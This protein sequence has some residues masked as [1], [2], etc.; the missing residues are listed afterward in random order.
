M[1]FATG[2]P[3]PTGEGETSH[4]SNQTRRARSPGITPSLLAL[5]AFLAALAPATTSQALSSKS[6]QLQ[7]P[8]AGVTARQPIHLAPKIATVTPQTCVR[9]GDAVTLGGSNFGFPKPAASTLAVQPAGG[10]TLITVTERSWSS[11]GITFDV[12]AGLAPESAF[13]AGIISGGAFIASIQL[14]VCP[15]FRAPNTRERS[16]F[17]RETLLGIRPIEPGGVPEITS[18]S[19]LECV[20]V[21]LTATANGVNLGATKLAAGFSLGY[22]ANN[23]LP[24]R[25]IL[26]SSWSP[27]GVSFI[28]PPEAGS[29]GWFAL[30]IILDSVFYPQQYVSICGANPGRSGSHGSGGYD[31][32]ADG[33]QDP[34]GEATAGPKGARKLGPGA[35]DIQIEPPPPPDETAP[36]QP[37]QQ[38][39]PAVGGKVLAMRALAGRGLHKVNKGCDLYD[40]HCPCCRK[41]NS[42]CLEKE[43]AGEDGT[44]LWV[45][46]WKQGAKTVDGHGVYDARSAEGDVEAVTGLQCDSVAGKDERSAGRATL[47]C[48]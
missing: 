24:T 8:Q 23:K 33:F 44:S 10:I 37:Q 40:P 26:E 9:P 13:T 1:R 18:V 39:K 3:M 27:T 16:S 15:K 43:S 29:G 17:S 31:G 7:E 6:I 46:S 47:N 20:T 38:G 36:E 25:E 14:T 45:V 41:D 11:T 35:V 12:P 42:V 48:R 30:G 28:V 34:G 21:G 32:G 4:P 2:F 22:Q 5:L 19:P